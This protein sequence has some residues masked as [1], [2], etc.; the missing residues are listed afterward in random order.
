MDINQLLLCAPYAAEFSGL[1]G[2]IVKIEYGIDKGI[3]CHV[4]FFFDGSVRNPGCHVH[5]AKSIGELWKKV[6][7]KGE[8]TYWNVNAQAPNFERQNCCAVGAIEWHDL[9]RRQHVQDY[10]IRYACKPDQI[11]H[12]KVGRLVRSIR[13]GVGPKRPVIR[14]GRPR[15]CHDVGNSRI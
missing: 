12:L 1:T 3:H 8:G 10:V 11:I 13:R 2:Y 9:K 7:T 4:T 14:I 5:H 15:Q 6:I